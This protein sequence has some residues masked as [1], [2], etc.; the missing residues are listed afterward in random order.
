LGDCLLWAVFFRKITEL[1]P[2]LVLL[3]FSTV[4]HMYQVI[5]GKLD[6]VTLWV[7]FSQTRRVTLSEVLA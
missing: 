7:I 1:A 3:F 2:I 5:L 4:K 6:W